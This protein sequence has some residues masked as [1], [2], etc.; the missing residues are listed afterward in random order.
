MRL[1]FRQRFHRSW[2]IA[3]ISWRVLRSDHSLGLFPVLSFIATMAF[4]A[5]MALIGYVTIGNS[6]ADGETV[7]NAVKAVAIVVGVVT[8]VGAAYIQVYFLAALVGSANE[9]LHGRT[10]SVGEGMKIASSRAG[11]LLPWAV[12]Q[13]TVSQIL[14]ALEERAGFIGSIAIGLVGAAWSVVT[15]LTVPIIVFE[16]AG[17][18]TAL[19]RSGTLLKKTWGENIIGQIGLGIVLLPAWLFMIGMVALAVWSANAL[20]AGLLILVGLLVFAVGL[21]IYNALMGI[22]RTALYRYAVD[23]TVPPAFAG[24]GLEQAFAP[25][26]GAA[27]PRSYL[28]TT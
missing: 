22:Y 7:S 25:K 27:E 16:D 8:Y 13:A 19:K 12:L 15:F 14:R 24:A 28:P 2:D 18:I 11:R 23:G 4:L 6:G 20:A 1:G 9:V 21:V 26:G 10:T 17:P 5:V 3:K